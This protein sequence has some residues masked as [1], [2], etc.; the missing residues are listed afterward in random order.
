MKKGSIEYCL[1]KRGRTPPLDERPEALHQFAPING[2]HLAGCEGQI[3][4][5]DQPVGAAFG[6][7]DLANPT[8]GCEKGARGDGQVPHLCG[9]GFETGAKNG[10][11]A[12]D[13]AN[14]NCAQ[15]A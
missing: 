9:A 4:E 5:E 11:E 6:I 2:G 15:T 10:S 8:A 1:L 3:W 14:E 13:C 7:N 12:G